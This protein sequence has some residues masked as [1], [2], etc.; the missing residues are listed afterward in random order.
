MNPNDKPNQSIDELMIACLTQQAQIEVLLSL[1]CRMA[2][3]LGIDP[4][5]GMSAENWFLR[6]KLA[7]LETMLIEIEDKSPTNAAFLQNIIDESRRRTGELP[8][9]L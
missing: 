6:E 9:G 5:N 4:F 1:C 7:Q 2:K 8:P 3:Q